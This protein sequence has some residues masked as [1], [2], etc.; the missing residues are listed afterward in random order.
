MR[1]LLRIWIAL[2]LF[3]V[4]LTL[5]VDRLAPSARV[6][7]TVRH[8]WPLAL[9]LLGVGG[10]LRL[11]VAT[12]N[13]L[14]GPMVVTV[15]GGL[16]LLV[17]LDPFSA[18]VQPLLWPAALLAAGTAMLV[19]LA[20]RASTADERLVTRLVSVAEG[21]RVVWPKGE[22]SLGTV[23]AVAS[24]CVIDLSEARLQEIR[25]ADTDELLGYEARI[26]ITAVLS[27]IDLMVPEGWR[28]R[29]EEY[30]DTQ[31]DDELPSKAPTL[32]I[33]TFSL[34]GGVRIRP[35]GQASGGS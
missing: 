9:V 27:G 10:A 31:R 29:H 2:A 24:G 32:R 5:L 35:E 26:D 21:R 33:K 8:W 34:L 17:T 20:V 12:K 19:A 6:L 25:D 3:G 1:S 14:R 11:L 30:P 15:A 7:A 22:F 16:L 4:G 13:V 18:S 28:V 23:T